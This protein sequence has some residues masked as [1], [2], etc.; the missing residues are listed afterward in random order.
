MLL[1]VRNVGIELSTKQELDEWCSLRLGDLFC[2]FFFLSII[3]R[4]ALFFTITKYKN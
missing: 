2:F 1:D 4:S 3:S